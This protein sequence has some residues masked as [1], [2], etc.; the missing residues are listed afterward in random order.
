MRNHDMTIG[1]NGSMLDQEPTGT[2]IYTINLINHLFQLYKLDNT[3]TLTVFTPSYDYLNP[4]VHTVKLANILQSSRYGRL[5]AFLRFFWNT[6][7]Y[8]LQARKFDVLISPTAHA[9]LF[10]SNQILTI[11][12]LLSMRFGNINGPQRLYFKLLLPYLVKKSRLVV[13]VSEASKRDI[14]KFLDCP[15]AKI[16]VVYN[17]Y[18]QTLF[19][20]TAK[21]NGL[22]KFLYG[23]SNY[24]LIVGPSYPHKNIELLLQ[25]YFLLPVEVREKYPLVLSGGKQP[26]L[27]L[28]RQQVTELGL[29]VY[30]HFL[31]YLPQHTMPDL[32][33]EAFALVFPSL[34]EGFGFPVLEAM[35]CGCPVIASNTSSIPEVCGEAAE[36]I[37]PLDRT[38]V[39]QA[40]LNLVNSPRRYSELRRRGL[41]Q[42][43]NFSW[44][45]TAAEIKKIIE[46]NL[47]N[48]QTP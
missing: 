10:S 6:F 12:D 21:S 5:A 13:T 27:R 3:R 24:F 36:Y 38:S 42:A 19:N 23:V 39:A 46:T 18:D 14:I 28:L 31:G 32:Y 11:H 26:Y 17:G 25:A 1:I 4:S 30:V 43:Q 22:I 37:D 2:G 29:G 41:I 48:Q 15:E 34:Y 20:V 47:L 35:A 7:I 8:P 44:E 40:M 16:K 9:S 45:R 33:R